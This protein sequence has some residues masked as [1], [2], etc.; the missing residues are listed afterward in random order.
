MFTDKYRTLHFH[1]FHTLQRFNVFPEIKLRGNPCSQ[2]P[3]SH[4]CGQFIS[5]QDR[6]T[7][8][9][10]AKK[11]DWLWEYINRSQIYERRNWDRHRTVSFLRIFLFQFS[12]QYLCDLSGILLTWVELS[13][14][15]RHP[16]GRRGAS[17][18]VWR[19]LPTQ[20]GRSYLVPPSSS[21][22]EKT[23]RF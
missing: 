16:W 9:A 22:V 4:I 5:S 2:F 7:Y 21:A 1:A 13:R 10:A 20:T 11:A 8:F 23:K 15:G 18:E 6:S 17:G 14:I 3:Y 19:G 12:V